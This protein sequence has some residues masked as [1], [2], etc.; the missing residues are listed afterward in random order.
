MGLYRWIFMEYW[1]FWKCKKRRGCS[2]TELGSWLDNKC[3][4][5]KQYSI[6]FLKKYNNQIIKDADN[7]FHQFGTA[8]IS[9]DGLVLYNWYDDMEHTF[10]SQKK[11]QKHYLTVDICYDFDIL[12]HSL[13]AVKLQKGDTWKYCF[14]NVKNLK[15]ST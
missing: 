13:F 8:A 15:N 6:F 5:N 9:K 4:Q 2:V 12:R 11:N 14:L 10:L 3:R 1:S 7:T